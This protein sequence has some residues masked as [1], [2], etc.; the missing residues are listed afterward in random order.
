MPT[1][2]GR[3]GKLEAMSRPAAPPQPPVAP[4][5][6]GFRPDDRSPTR[7]RATLV[8]G[9]SVVI[10]CLGLWVYA[11]FVYDPGR[12]VDELADRRFPT[13]AEKVCAA[14][15]EELDRLPAA[16]TAGSAA[17]RAVVVEEANAILTAMVTDLQPL[18][19]G[20]DGVE[21]EAVREWLGDWERHLEDRRDYAR[22]LR[23]D[24]DARFTES[25]KG[26]RQLSRAI[27]GFAEVNRMESCSTPGDVG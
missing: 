2:R 1:G 11:L 9:A 22:S 8:L 13:A 20:G 17:E 5:G 10:I 24:P 7:R 12:L 21:A 25:V 27:D 19:P 3:D 23:E 6:T 26:T 15:I 16:N 18:A 14:A 4:P